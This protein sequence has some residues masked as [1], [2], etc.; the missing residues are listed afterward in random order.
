[1]VPSPMTLI[2]LLG[3]FS[4]FSDNK[5]RLIV[6]SLIE[7]PDDLTK[8]DIAD[9]LEWPFKVISDAINGFLVCIA[10][11]QQK[12]SGPTS[13]VVFVRKDWYTMLNATC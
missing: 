3:Y 1:M 9:Y 4:Y 2:D 10:K 8:D 12:H 7:S 11:T 13:T 5:C 6:R